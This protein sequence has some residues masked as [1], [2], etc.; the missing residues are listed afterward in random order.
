MLNKIINDPKHRINQ[1][2]ETLKSEFGIV[3]DFADKA[4]LQELEAFAKNTVKSIK[5]AE[6]FNEH[7]QNSQAV[8]ALL[9][10]EAIKI[11]R[12]NK[13]KKTDKKS[14]KKELH[15]LE[16]KAYATGATEKEQKAAKALKKK[17]KENTELDKAELILA[18][19]NIVDDLQSMSEKVSKIQAEQLPAIVDRIK[20]EN[21]LGDAA[22]YREIAN[23]QLDAVIAA[24]ATAKEDIDN[25]TLGL[26]GDVAMASVD[27]SMGGV[28]TAPEQVTGDQEAQAE[29]PP[30]EQPQERER[31]EENAKINNKP[32]N[33][34]AGKLRNWECVVTRGSNTAKDG[35]QNNVVGTWDIEASNMAEAIAKTKKAAL[36]HK[37]AEWTKD[38]VIKATPGKVLEDVVDFP[39]HKVTP[40][41]TQAK[42]ATITSVDDFEDAQK[43]KHYADRAEIEHAIYKKLLRPMFNANPHSRPDYHLIKNWVERNFPNA[44]ENVVTNVIED[45]KHFAGTAEQTRTYFGESSETTAMYP[46]DHLKVGDSV[47]INDPVRPTKPNEQK[48]TGVITKINN[49]PTYKHG[50][51]MIYVK[52]DQGNEKIHLGSELKKLKEAVDTTELALGDRV[53]HKTLGKG[54]VV[55][56]KENGFIT[57]QF[58]DG[59]KLAFSNRNS[60]ALVAESFKKDDEVYVAAKGLAQSGKK[61]KVTAADAMGATV[62]FGK[63]SHK[64]SNKD[65]KKLKE[66][67]SFA[68]MKE[69]ASV[70]ATSAGAIGTIAKPLF[71]K[72]IKRNSQESKRVCGNCF[73]IAED[74][75]CEGGL[76]ETKT[77][78]VVVVETTNGKKGKKTFM[79]EKEAKAWVSKHGHHLKSIKIDEA[80]KDEKECPS[81]T[82]SGYYKDDNG[83]KTE[84]PDCSGQGYYDSYGDSIKESAVESVWDRHKEMEQ[85]AT[86]SIKTLAD[87]EKLIGKN[88]ARW[89]LQN[90]IKALSFAP[91]MNTLDDYKKLRAAKLLLKSKPA[92]KK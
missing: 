25:L 54:K 22:N 75:S 28:A 90:M 71:A 63:T 39:S 82:G 32:L 45:L 92:V 41:I 77:S 37:V 86:D 76:K 42:P 10:L 46:S 31:K 53:K 64:F 58:E 48:K 1:V 68:S 21:G 38:L 91:L 44:N 9:V 49:T 57:I 59:K 66:S 7:H 50:K 43:D 69:N 15:D 72:P 3:L 52:D 65:L 19:K 60:E 34:E 79:N 87:A 27:N 40:A 62:D 56:C 11:H 33:E 30:V 84:C 35:R 81:C 23:M 16:F 74:C 6:S 89:E 78:I 67:P 18:S 70:G 14:L 24:L 12:E 51:R 5:E 36:R 26:S 85:E 47:I 73:A 88:R 83:K 2:L 13:M 55:S 17:L 20:L 61:G 8:C 4:S 80:K 29:L